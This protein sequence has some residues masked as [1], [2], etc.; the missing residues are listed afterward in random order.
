MADAGFSDWQFFYGTNNSD[1]LDKWGRGKDYW[2]YIPQD[3]A[4]LLRDNEPPLLI[5]EDDIQPRDYKPYV[6]VPIGA[7]MVYLGGGK[8]GDSRGTKAAF[9]NLEDEEIYRNHQHSFQIIDDEWMRIFGMWFSHAILHI[10]KMVMLE[11]ADALGARRPIDTTLAMQQWRW[12]VV[13][14]RVPMWWQDDG[15]HRYDTFDYNP[16]PE[17]AEAVTRQPQNRQEILRAERRKAI[18]RKRQ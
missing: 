13:C 2:L 6:A 10:N 12:N 3:H 15:K 14:R 11:V 8:G 4:K 5:L 7:E 17:R 9:R 16:N 1:Q 18:S